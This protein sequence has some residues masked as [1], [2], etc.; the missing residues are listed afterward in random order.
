MSRNT[1][2]ENTKWDQVMEHFDLLFT[3]L[4]DLSVVQQQLKSQLDIRGA[5]M[6]QYSQEQHMIAQ[7]VKAN[8]QAVAQLTLRQFQ[9]EA[10]Q[11][12][13]SDGAF[14]ILDDDASFKNVFAHSKDK[15]KPEPSKSKK[16]H[17][18]PA[19]STK[20]PKHAI[21][22]MPFPIFDGTDPKI[23]KDNCE[24]Y[25]ELY[26]LP[27]G[28]WITAATL[29][30]RDNAAKWFQAYKQTNALGTWEQ[31]C[32]AVQQEFGAD[33]LRSAMNELLELRQIG[34]VEDYTTTFQALQFN[35]IM[36]NPNYDDLF[37]TPKY[38]MGLKDEIRAQVEPHLPP[39]VRK[40]ATIAKI[41]QGLL[42]R[43]KTRQNR[44]H[45]AVR[46]YNNPRA[47][48]KST[49]QSNQLWKDRQLRD[50]R[51]ANGLCFSCGE[52][53]IPGHLEC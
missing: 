11:E 38:I 42:E 3:Q 16:F 5:A 19:D 34:T 29:H 36:H 32:A 51:R 18:P 35:I 2:E 47:K 48:P 53:F 50:Y 44:N 6:D 15:A 10:K 23:W 8:G 41:Q 31:F 28:M 22:K 52:N 7:Q 33:D 49:Q 40:A 1:E 30:F 46:P 25:F 20:L 12:E 24:S 37:F 17:R 9:T 43:A 13:D 45:V 4:N 27:E 21:P 26:S 14:D 39:T